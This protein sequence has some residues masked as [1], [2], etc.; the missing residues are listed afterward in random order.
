MRIAVYTDYPYRRQGESVY[1]ER[2]F[3]IFLAGLA[4]HVDRLVLLGRLHP[5]AV[6]SSRSH[7]R[8]VPEID[9]VPLPYYE[10]LARPR[11]ALARMGG[12]LRVFWRELEG[13]DGVWLLGPHAFGLLFA[14]AAFAR[15]KRVFLGVRQDLPRYVRSR[16]PSRRALHL[17]ADLLE[18]SYRL[19]A[20]GCPTI[21]VGPGLAH[22]Y[23]RARRLLPISV[24]LVNESDLAAAKKVRRSYAGE[25][26]ALSVGR[27]EPEKNPLL[28]AD[29]IAALDGRW[30][31]VVCGEGPLE[32]ELRR[33][34]EELGAD[35][36]AEL[37]GYLPLDAGLMDLYRRSHALLHISWTEG[38]PQVLF[39]AF[40][41][42]LPIVATAVGGVREAVGDDALLVPPGGA[43]EPTRA[44]ERIADDEELRDRLV[45]GG[46]ER[47]RSRTLEAET[48]RV[49]RF[50]ATA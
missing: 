3:V 46:L 4:R 18:L 33:R 23:R 34:L 2:A 14:A 41:S 22:H 21:V 17:A 6:R 48:A 35:G 7:Y 20:I 50:M 43:G 28:L 8:L 26:T 31:L 36:R 37:V 1:A 12:S 38:V 47:A 13:V 5:G 10:T 40:A 32:G 49:A 25:L 30:R 16:H 24:T 29:V 19:L 11:E 39:E 9:F 15:R 44:L 27:L 45:T 42:T